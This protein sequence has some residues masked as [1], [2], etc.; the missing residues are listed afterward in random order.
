MI[1][2]PSAFVPPPNVL[3]IARGVRTLVHPEP[4]LHGGLS[5]QECVIPHIVSRSLF[6][7]ARVGLKL[8]V[9]TP[10]LTAGTVPVIL[11]PVVPAE[12][13]GLGG[14]QPL[15]LLLWV[16]TSGDEGAEPRLVT[17]KQSIELRPEV[18]E[19]KP[20]VY[21]QEGLNLPSGQKLL[22]WA[23]DAETGRELGKVPLT[24]LVDWD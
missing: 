21:L 4:Y 10:N 2:L 6:R 1:R 12:Q 16:E 20:A 19:L 13:Q 23:V 18:E 15:K 8:Q 14:L 17:E 24:L 3:G 22:L 5:L 11:R 9:S 7:T